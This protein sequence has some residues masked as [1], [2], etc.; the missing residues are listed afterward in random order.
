MRV[1]RLR[2]EKVPTPNLP[3]RVP[4][5]TR[6]S[7]GPGPLCPARGRD[8]STR[9]WRASQVV[10]SLP[11]SRHA[12]DEAAEAMFASLAEQAT[13]EVAYLPEPLLYELAELDQ[14]WLSSSTN[15][16]LVNLALLT[17]HGPVS[18][19]YP[20]ARRQIHADAAVRPV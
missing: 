1:P 19:S 15:G 3:T 2:A 5:G 16:G 10:L 8:C 18:A 14:T 6:K 9:V 4:I 7:L 20:Q 13:E 12:T 11:V 17:K